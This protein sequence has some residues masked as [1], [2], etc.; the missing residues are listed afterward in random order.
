MKTALISLSLAT[1]LGLA[2]YVSALSFNAGQLISVLFVAGL[3]AWTIT[4]YGRKLKPLTL[5]VAR[6]IHLPIKMNHRDLSA[7]ASRLAA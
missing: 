1:L 6:P 5:T 3:A 4:L 2:S 7:Q